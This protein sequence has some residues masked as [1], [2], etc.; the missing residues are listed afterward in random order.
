MNKH[1]RQKAEKQITPGDAPRRENIII[2]RQ[3]PRVCGK[4][5]LEP[6][7]MVLNYTPNPTTH[8]GRKGLETLQMHRQIARAWAA[9]NGSGFNVH[10]VTASVQTSSPAQPHSG[11]SPAGERPARD[12]GSGSATVPPPYP[13]SITHRRRTIGDQQSAE[14][15]RRWQRERRQAGSPPAYGERCPPVPQPAPRPR[16]VTGEELRRNPPVTRLVRP[17]RGRAL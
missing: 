6:V 5:V 9:E 1:K 4:P 17:K 14:R 11:R 10:T 8:E 2:G 12:G 7:T 16:R 13:P 3:L 15:I